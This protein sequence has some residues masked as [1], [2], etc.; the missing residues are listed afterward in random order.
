MVRR[1]APADPAGPGRATLVVLQTRRPAPPK[2][3][4]PVPAPR[5]DPPSSPPPGGTRPVR[6]L[7]HHLR[8]LRPGSPAH[9]WDA[10]A[11]C[12]SGGN[13]SINT[14]NGYYGGL[15]FSESTG[16]AYGGGALRDAGD[17]ATRNEQTPSPSGFWR[18]RARAPGRSA[19]AASDVHPSRRNGHSAGVSGGYGWTT[20]TVAVN[21]PPLLPTPT[22]FM[23]RKSSPPCRS[24]R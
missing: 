22:S 12:E 2:H 23:P 16:L 8:R 9:D 4:D 7:P 18:P 19:A 24:S 17:L 1:A 20:W 21:A 5:S 11:Q 10:V 13:W 3:A 6:R 14:G 15:Q